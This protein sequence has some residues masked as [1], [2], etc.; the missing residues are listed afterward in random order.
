MC[1]YEE[2][3]V[4]TNEVFKFGGVNFFID[5]LIDKKVKCVIWFGRFVRIL[6]EQWK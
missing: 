5:I 2:K 3:N 6:E 1:N 4:V